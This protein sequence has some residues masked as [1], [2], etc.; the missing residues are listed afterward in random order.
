MPCQIREMCIDDYDAVLALWQSCEGVG[1]SEDDSREGIERY[2]RRNP[3]LSVVAVHDGRIVGA[4]LCG[5]D[6]RRGC[7]GHVAVEASC[8]GHGIGR[9]IV[10]HC[11]AGLAQQGIRKCNIIVFRPNTAGAA[12]WEKIGWNRRDDLLLMQKT[13]FTSA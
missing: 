2:L 11:L 1:L 13:L 6:G 10:E 5:H 4:A 3:G 12:F 9:R 8:R 7:L